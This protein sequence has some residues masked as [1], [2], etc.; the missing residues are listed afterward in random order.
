[1]NPGSIEAK[2]QNILRLARAIYDHPGI[3]RKELSQQLGLSPSTVTLATAPLLEQGLI[4]EC[5]M[6]EAPAGRRAKLLRINESHGAVLILRLD[7]DFSLKLQLC[8]L[9]GS[10]LAQQ[11]L[12]PPV[13]RP[14]QEQ[15]PAQLAAAAQHFLEQNPH[16]FPL[17]ATAVIT[18]GTMN[19]DG[20]ADIVLFGWE[21]LDLSCLTHSL[22]TPVYYDSILHMLGSYEV[23]QM[24]SAGRQIYLS[25]EPGVGMTCYEQGQAVSSRNLFYGEVGHISMHE[26]GPPCY[27]GNRGCLEYYCGVSGILSRLSQVANSCPILSNLC[28]DGMSLELLPK[29]ARQGSMLAGQLLEQV[30]TEL[31]RALVTLMNLLDPDQILIA[32]QLWQFPDIREPVLALTTLRALARRR[33]LPQIQAASLNPD[34]SEIGICHFVFSRWIESQI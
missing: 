21:G 3:S 12:P 30:A 26:E 16:P 32:G 23:R 18:P 11:T 20:T 2:K 13:R 22:H 24:P 34:H 17:L 27:C 14:K 25:L 6:E 28:Q 7:E 4:T 29:A 1:M 19:P 5:G 9:C 33:Q 31:G 8:N 15:F 10:L